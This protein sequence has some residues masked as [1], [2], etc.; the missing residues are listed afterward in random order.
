MNTEKERR[1][2]ERA[3]WW[4]N[5]VAFGIGILM[6][7]GGVLAY[8]IGG[9]EKNFY[10]FIAPVLIIFGALLLPLMWIQNTAPWKQFENWFLRAVLR[11]KV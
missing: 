7:V 9:D 6:L 5:T 4:N 8:F 3:L 10:T 1:Q 11:I 2:R